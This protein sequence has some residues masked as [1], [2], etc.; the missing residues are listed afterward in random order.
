MNDIDE[1][2]FDMVEDL[3][4]QFRDAIRD[5]ASLC[6]GDKILEM[7]DFCP[8]SRYLNSYLDIFF[9]K[10]DIKYVLIFNKI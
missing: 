3:F 5:P 1:E 9:Y 2:I 10:Q 4:P 8:V 7:F 6:N